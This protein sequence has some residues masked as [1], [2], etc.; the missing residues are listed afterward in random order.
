MEYSEYNDFLTSLLQ[1]DDLS[2]FKLHP[3]YNNIL[4]HVC[5]DYGA[6]YLQ[7]TLE[8]FHVPIEHIKMYGLMNDSVGGPHKAYYH[9]HGIRISPTS[10]RYIFHALLILAHMKQKN[11]TS[12][13][14]VEVGCGYGG[15]ALAIDF[16]S[17]FF[18]IDIDRYVCVD[19]P[20]PLKL[21][22]KFLSHFKLS[23]TLAFE[24]A[25]TFG[26]NL[27]GDDYFLIS[28]YCFSEISKEFQEKYIKQLF[29][30]CRH[31]FLTWNHIDVY[32][33]GKVVDVQI[34]YPLT[35]AKNKYVRF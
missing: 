5:D 14:V 16:F 22:E 23:L 28:N 30:K 32:D 26:E 18:S 27:K 20:A 17:K 24:P 3:N 15:L 25:E 12:V 9:H 7:L 1:S 4:E 11:L 10:L 21:Q 8:M 2:N 13:K 31:G 6:Q 35:S 33:I 29:P 34:E 19:L